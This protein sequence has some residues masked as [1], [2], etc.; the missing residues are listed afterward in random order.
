MK[1]K[2][3]EKVGMLRAFLIIAII[4]IA[5]MGYLVYKLYTEKANETEKISSLNNQIS[6]L[7]NTDK[8]SGENDSTDKEDKSV[9]EKATD[10]NQY[11]EKF[12]NS[13]TKE[14]GDDNEIYINLASID[15]NGGKGYVS[16]NN[17]HEA[18]IYINNIKEYSVASNL[19]KIS[20]NVIN[21]WYCEEGQ[22][23]G[24]SYIVFLKEDGT[25]TYVRF[26]TDNST[27]WKTT[28]EAEE[29]E[30]KGIKDIIDIIPINGGDENGI[31]GM[32]VLLINKDGTCL[33][34]STLEDLTK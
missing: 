30:F 14:L 28:F 6:Q 10:T 8:T 33:P 11:I 27:N 26:R 34:Y 32:G 5:V 21:A 13:V 16:I 1:E 31:G 25:V 2:N 18:H 24:N 4:I 15:D 9:S 3:G 22:A 12:N 7:K 29:K 17:K 23:P 20:D 19:K